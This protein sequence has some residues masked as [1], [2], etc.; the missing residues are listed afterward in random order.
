MQPDFAPGSPTAP[1]PDA[2]V[3]ARDAPPSN[4][5]ALSLLEPKARRK[6]SSANAIAGALMSNTDR[7]T[8]AGTP[9]GRRRLWHAWRRHWHARPGP[10]GRAM[11]S[12]SGP[13]IDLPGGWQG[14]RRGNDRR[15]ATS[16]GHFRR[17]ETSLANATDG[18]LAAAYRRIPIEDYSLSGVPRLTGCGCE[19]PGSGRRLRPA[20][21]SSRWTG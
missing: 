3:V 16:V 13:R 4:T 5:T 6:A 2:A 10:R 12:R 18:A 8:R 1:P 20:R 11:A 9:V 14:M 21:H 19:A 17:S 7:D 15:L